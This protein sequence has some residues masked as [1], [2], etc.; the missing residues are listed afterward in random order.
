M[1]STN[2]TRKSAYH[3]NRIIDTCQLPNLLSIDSKQR[4][5]PVELNVPIDHLVRAAMKQGLV[6]PVVM[7]FPGLTVGGMFLVA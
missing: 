5:A 1:G 3:G 2:S 6:S 4:T 7:E